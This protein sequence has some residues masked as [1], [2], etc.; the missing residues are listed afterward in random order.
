M[1]FQFVALQMIAQGPNLDTTIL[2]LLAAAD[3]L[4]HM[5]MSLQTAEC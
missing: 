2:E 1:R 5:L 4:L 3:K